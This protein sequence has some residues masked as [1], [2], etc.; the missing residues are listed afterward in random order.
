MLQLTDI[1]GATHYIAADN[2]CRI[3][4]AGLSSQWHGIKSIVR[5][6]DGATIECQQDAKTVATRAA[7]EQFV[8]RG[9]A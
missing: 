8:I 2:I 3:T 6:F 4:E 5:L 9:G 7:A 1:N